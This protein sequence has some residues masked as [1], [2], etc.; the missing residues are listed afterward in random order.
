MKLTLG[1]GSEILVG[2]LGF[3]LRAKQWKAT[4]K[5]QQGRDIVLIY[6][7]NDF[8]CRNWIGKEPVIVGTEASVRR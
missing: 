7:L 2:R 5:L 8:L 1:E 6:S 3:A 4:G